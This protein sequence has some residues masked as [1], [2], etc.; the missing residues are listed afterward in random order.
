MVLSDRK[1]WIIY[2]LACFSVLL[3]VGLSAVQGAMIIVAMIITLAVASISAILCMMLI[4]DLKNNTPGG[5]GI[6][7]S[8][9]APE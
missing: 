9:Q 4:S 1:F 6:S 7:L 2:I 5:A 3:W 8:S